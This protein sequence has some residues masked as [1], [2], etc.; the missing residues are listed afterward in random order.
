[1]KS[2]YNRLEHRGVRSSVTPKIVV[3]L[4]GLGLMRAER[5]PQGLWSANGRN[6]KIGSERD[7]WLVVWNFFYL[8]ILYCEYSSQLTFIFFSWVGPPPTRWG[9]VFGFFSS[10]L[11]VF[12]RFF[13]KNDEKNV[14]TLQKPACL[15]IFQSFRV[16][17]KFSRLV[18]DSFPTG[19]QFPKT[20]ARFPRKRCAISKKRCRKWYQ[21]LIRLFPIKLKA[22]PFVFWFGRVCGDSGDPEMCFFVIWRDFGDLERFEEVF[23]GFGRVWGGF[24]KIWINLKISVALEWFSYL[25]GIWKGFWWFRNIRR[26]CLALAKAGRRLGPP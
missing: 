3:D 12:A 20:G 23:G 10:I 21:I 13:F 18:P 1:M 7:D 14:K 4:R 2:P 6:V 26:P 22:R 15:T 9:S 25:E 11:Q 16:V 24:L 8:S 5:N 17:R 19:A